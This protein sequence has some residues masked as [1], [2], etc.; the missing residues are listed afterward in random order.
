M[1]STKACQHCG[2]S[3]IDTDPARGDAVCTN[4]GSVL[5]DSIIVSE[6]Q[7][8]ENAHGGSRAIGQLISADGTSGR[9]LGGFQHGSGKESRAL[10][11]QKAR[12]KI[13]QVAE[14]LRLNQ[15]CIDTAFNFYKMALTR[16]L[17]RGR[18]HSHVVAACIYMV[19]RIEG[20]PHMLLD[21][22]DVVQVNV[23][24]LGKTFLKLSSALCINI[25]AIDP[26]LYIVRFAHHLEFADK[27]HEVSMTALRLVQRMKRDW[28]HTGRRP[29][30]LCGAALLV[31]SRLHDF[32]RTIK[33]LVRVVKVCE[34]TIRK[35]LTEFG[36]TPSSRLTL[37]EF[38]TIDLEEEQDPPCFKA[39]RRKQKGAL[40]DPGKVDRA[41]Q[42]VSELQKKIEGELEDRRRKVRGRF[43][44]FAKEDTLTQEEEKEISQGFI[45]ENTMATIN[46]CLDDTQSSRGSDN[47]ATSAAPPPLRVTS[48]PRDNDEDASSDDVATEAEA[49]L[50]ERNRNLVT[51]LRPTAATLGLKESIEECMR[52]RDC[53]EDTEETDAEVK[54]KTR[55]WTMHHAEYLKE[56][57]EKEARRAQEMEENANKPE[58]K[59]GTSEVDLVETASVVSE[60]TKKKRKEKP[61][62]KLTSLMS[63]MKSIAMSQ[64][65][66][67]RLDSDDETV[68]HH[69]NIWARNI[70]SSCKDEDLDEDYEEKEQHLSVAQLLGQHRGEEQ[71]EYYMEEADD[72]ID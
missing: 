64:P 67:V 71:D 56:Q 36:D 2:C 12:R 43:A 57:E 7:F 48:E 29:S 10:T 33:D 28:M 55:F 3:E 6:I 61:P 8:E 37:E 23:Y 5:E 35:R 49:P 72:Y 59:K 53:I 26:C 63:T 65:K 70:N 50:T 18:R 34:T 24:E 47:G 66:E 15:H 54:L 32:S 20:T 51:S 60:T 40:D 30:G 39:A 38:M 19:C 1:S 21:L 69:Q 45:I 9:S 41:T 11:L 46:D 58:P 22:S 27:T 52:V 68:P 62:P 4:C 25:P 31:A 17:T 13:V 44:R 42:E 14:R 16:H